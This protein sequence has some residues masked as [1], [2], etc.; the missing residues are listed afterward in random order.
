MLQWFWLPRT[1]SKFWE[2]NHIIK[3]AFWYFHR[4]LLLLLLCIGLSCIHACV[5]NI[6]SLT[7]TIRSQKLFFPEMAQFSTTS[8]KFQLSLSFVYTPKQKF[9]LLSGSFYQRWTLSS[10]APWD[11]T[12]PV[13]T[14]VLYSSTYEP[15][16]ARIRITLAVCKWLRTTIHHTV[17]VQT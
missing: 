5:C 7:D 11:Q 1:E 4:H 3:T 17:A 12:Q 15:S 8:I 2:Q 10:R 16:H 9:Q 14:Q 13:K 6:L